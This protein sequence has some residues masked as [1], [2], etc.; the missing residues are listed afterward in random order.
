[1][2]RKI[3]GDS[4][5]VEVRVQVYAEPMNKF[6]KPAV[7]FVTLFADWEAVEE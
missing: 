4:K 7:E 2:A 6:S 5:P 1:V 3:I